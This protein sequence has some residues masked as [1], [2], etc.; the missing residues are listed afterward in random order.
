M[1]QSETLNINILNGGVRL[2]L[3]ADCSSSAVE[4]VLF[5]GI[6]KIIP[7]TQDEFALI[8]DEDFDIIN[9]F[10]W[11]V[12]RDGNNIYARTDLEINRK[13]YIISM[14]RLIL[15]VPKGKDT[16][17]KSGNGLDNQKNN[18]RICTCQQNQWNQRGHRNKSSEYKGVSWQY[19]KNKWRATIKYNYKQIYL[20][21][22][23]DE[24]IAAKAYD[25]VAIN[26][27]GEFARLNN[28][29]S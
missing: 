19:D 6:M 1:L 25:F 9:L 15:N 24:V 8:D 23:R 13:K 14:H 21:T 16:D 3:K 18:L 29:E 26:L 17:H 27:F 7:L 11:Y 5:G 12:K 20:G 4:D 2:P 22:Y 10:K 28:V